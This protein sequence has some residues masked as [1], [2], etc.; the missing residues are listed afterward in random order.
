MGAE[1]DSPRF[2]GVIR[3]D[4]FVQEGRQKHTDAIKEGD[5]SHGKVG[6]LSRDHLR[7]LE[8]ASRVETEDTRGSDEDHETKRFL[9]SRVTK[10]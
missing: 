10:G 9:S 5:I 2:G 1:D 6:M 7:G 4:E 3:G 8:E